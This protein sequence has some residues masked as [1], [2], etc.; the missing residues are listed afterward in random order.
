MLVVLL[1]VEGGCSRICKEGRIA[2]V[3]ICMHIGK[4]RRRGLN[5]TFS[6]WCGRNGKMS[7][8]FIVKKEEVK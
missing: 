4:I 2:R 1:E 3:I 7:G 8:R 5:W 6:D